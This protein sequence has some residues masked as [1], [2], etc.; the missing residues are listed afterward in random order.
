MGVA[1]IIITTTTELLGV[2]QH[3]GGGSQTRKADFA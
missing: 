1:A 2:D 3:L